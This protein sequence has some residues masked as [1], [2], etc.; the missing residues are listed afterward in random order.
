MLRK[1]GPEPRTAED[2]GDLSAPRSTAMPSRREPASSCRRPCAV[3]RAEDKL[4]KPKY[5]RRS[6]QVH[7][8]EGGLQRSVQARSAHP[9]R[10]VVGRSSLRMSH[11]S[12]SRCGETRERRSG[13]SRGEPRGE[14]ARPVLGERLRARFERLNSSVRSGGSECAH[15]KHPSACRAV[16]RAG[17]G[18]DCGS[19]GTQ[20]DE[21]A[22]LPR[23]Y[24]GVCCSRRTSYESVLPATASACTLHRPQRNDEPLPRLPKG[25]HVRTA[26]TADERRRDQHPELISAF[27]AGAQ[28][29]LRRVPR[30]ERG[31]RGGR[32]TDEARPWSILAWR[33]AGI[34][35]AFAEYTLTPCATAMGAVFGYGSL[36]FKPPPHGL[37]S[38]AGYI[39][40]FVR[41]FAQKSHDHRGTPERPGRG[42]LCPSRASRP[43]AA[44]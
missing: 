39:K 4:D 28:P 1:E 38:K 7:A 13:Q 35:R 30:G 6:M 14:G 9:A 44:R 31:G 40:G 12:L 29:L 8:R 23:H 19:D 36:I 26:T 5:P 17:A 22:V 20:R 11:A 2:S 16:S 21:S 27:D 37:E 33:W 24:C 3:T 43:L 42:A 15:G 25:A 32:Q 41:R 34:T 10:A 18:M